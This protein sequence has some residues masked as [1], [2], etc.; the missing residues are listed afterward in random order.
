MLDPERGAWLD[1]TSGGSTVIE[2]FAV[3][4]SH[5]EKVVP[6]LDGEAFLRRAVDATREPCWRLDRPGPAPP[7]ADPVGAPP[8][9]YGI[10]MDPTG[11]LAFTGLRCTFDWSVVL[12]DGIAF[13]T[14]SS[15]GWPDGHAKKL[16]G[17]ES[18]RPLW[19]HVARDA[20]A[21][22]SVFGHDALLT[23][24]LP[25]RWRR[26]GDVWVAERSRGEP[27]TL[28]FERGDDPAAFP[29]DPCVGD[30]DARDRV[31][32]VTLGPSSTLRY[33]VD[34]SAPTWRLRG[35]AGELLGGREAAWVV[36][37]DE[38]RPVRRAAGRL[39]GGWDRWVVVAREDELVRVDL[40][41]ETVERLGVV[42]R[43]IDAAVPLAG[44]PNV[45]LVSLGPTTAWL[46]VV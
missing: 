42:D 41:A 39:L 40:V 14:P 18:N 21:C 30:E 28:L 17:Y 7:T 37:D 9:G 5:W 26:A 46:R 38:H 6:R 45:V 43:P 33:A 15:H 34:V 25:L 10:G 4:T 32:A 23:P 13:W 2:G 29:G 22:L 3:A 8:I 12:D 36:F 35:R 11:R 20:S 19:V 31:A 44:T 1:L 24:G 16:Y 27:R